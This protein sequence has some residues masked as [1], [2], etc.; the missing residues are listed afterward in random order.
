MHP[1]CLRR[2]ADSWTNT[3][4]ER[5]RSPTRSNLLEL[6]RLFRYLIDTV[7]E[8]PDDLVVEVGRRSDPRP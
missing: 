1:A 8:R 6:R 3:S 4:S 5:K 2:P 7:L